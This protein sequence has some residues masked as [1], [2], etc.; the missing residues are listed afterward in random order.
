[1]DS[2]VQSFHSIPDF[3][4]NLGSSVKVHKSVRMKNTEQSVN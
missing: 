1:M 3:L 4:V 2:M